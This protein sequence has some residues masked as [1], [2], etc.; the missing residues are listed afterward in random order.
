MRDTVVHHGAQAFAGDK[1]TPC[2]HHAGRFGFPETLSCLFK[3]RFLKKSCSFEGFANLFDG[4]GTLLHHFSTSATLVS[5]M[6]HLFPRD[7][8]LIAGCVVPILQHIFMLVKYHHYSGWLLIQLGLEAYFQVEVLSN[9]DQFDSGLGREITNI[10]RGLALSMLAAHYMYLA[11]ALCHLIH[12]AFAEKKPKSNV[13]AGSGGKRKIRMQ[14][15]VH[16]FWQM[17]RE[18]DSDYVQSRAEKHQRAWK[19][20]GVLGI[21]YLGDNELSEESR[22]IRLVATAAKNAPKPHSDQP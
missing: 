19:K 6:L 17:S 15:T 2:P 10:G 1:V 7:R 21:L 9:V 16:H 5:I 22:S 12:D 11:G 4:F 3:F 20:A 14:R 8:A 13:G 18:L